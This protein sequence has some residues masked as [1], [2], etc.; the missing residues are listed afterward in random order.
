M[1]RFLAQSVGFLLVAG[2]VGFL[3]VVTLGNR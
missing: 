1:R 2:L 3:L